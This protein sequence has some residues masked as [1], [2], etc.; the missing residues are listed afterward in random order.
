MG[1]H[2][3]HCRDGKAV[4]CI[5]DANRDHHEEELNLDPGPDTEE[6]TFD[7]GDFTQYVDEEGE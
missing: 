1:L 3:L 5:C 6:F 2:H 4:P 7:L